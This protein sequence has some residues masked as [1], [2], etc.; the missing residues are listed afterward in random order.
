MLLAAVGVVY[1]CGPE[2][3]V[4]P[5][6]R[7]QRVEA[8]AAAITRQYPGARTRTILAR[9]GPLTE[10]QVRGR[11]GTPATH[12]ERWAAFQIPAG[13]PTVAAASRASAPTVLATQSV[14]AD[15]LLGTLQVVAS[16][17]F[18]EVSVGSRAT[19]HGSLVAN[20]QAWAY[21]I[22]SVGTELPWS[23]P[24]PVYCNLDN[25]F[26]CS[27]GELYSIDCE[28][29]GGSRVRANSE[30]FV[31][32]QDRRSG[33]GHVDRDKSCFPSGGGGNGGGGGPTNCETW[34]VE[35]SYD[36]GVTW[37]EIGRFTICDP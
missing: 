36:G 34:I 14:I 20:I 16:G 29:P 33:D 3:A 17:V 22:I 1:G 7:S 35:I 10:G 18:G 8:L 15:T 26:F 28:A 5:G 6:N 9:P 23:P 2:R 27:A 30:H 13:S 12:P 11:I 19:E 31:R 32:Y 25:A 24:T 4:A 21:P 37:S